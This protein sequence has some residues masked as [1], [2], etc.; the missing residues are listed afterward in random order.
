MQFRVRYDYVVHEGSRVYH[1]GEVFT[2]SPATLESQGW[3]LD[4]VPESKAI[5]DGAWVG[6]RCF[7]VGGGPSLINFDFS[8]LRGELAIGINRAFEKMDPTIIFSMDNRFYTWLQKGTFG[9]Q[10][11]QKYQDSQACKIWVESAGFDF[12][13]EVQTVPKLFGRGVSTSLAEGLYLG[14]NSGFTALNLAICLGAN[15]IYLLGFDLHTRGQFQR[16]F[17][18]GYPVRQQDDIYANFRE[19]FEEVAPAIEERGIKVINLNL[20]SALKCFDFGEMPKPLEDKVMVITPTGDRP[21]A[22]ALLR[23]WMVAQTRQPDQWLIIDDGKKPVKP[24]QFPMA[25]VIR[26]EP[27]ADDPTCTLGKNLEVALSHVAHDKILIM[28]DDDWYAPT[29][30][31]TMAALLNDHE[32]AGIWGTKCY[33][34][35]VPGFREMGREDHASLSQ[36]GFRKS[37]IP[38]VI[39]SIPGDCSVDLRLWWDHNGGKGH[40][41]PGADKRLHC[42]I[43][44]LPGRPGAG[45]RERRKARDSA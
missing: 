34:L 14:S 38:Q 40:L 6:R 31:E 15:P 28:E 22:L 8:Q 27:R 39:A 35:G 33:H 44:G 19:D 32:L 4:L 24:K 20:A 42:A 21:E 1:P 23:N 18:D 13:S 25:T 41:I 9:P 11:L 29:Y 45:W 43:K 16:W 5:S 37:M 17:H 3:K 30:I 26:R 36:T 12:G 2:P 7:I 10:V